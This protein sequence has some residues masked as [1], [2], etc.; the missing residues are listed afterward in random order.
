MNEKI[1]ILY[2]KIFTFLKKIIIFFLFLNKKYL[3][4]IDFS[5]LYSKIK[6][7]MRGLL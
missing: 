4:F 5:I 7:K 2:G 1:L 6:S 3:Y